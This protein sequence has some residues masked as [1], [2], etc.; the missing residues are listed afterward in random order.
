MFN[1]HQCLQIISNGIALELTKRTTWLALGRFATDSGFYGLSQKPRLQ[2][3]LNLF[4]PIGEYGS[5]TSL[6]P[7]LPYTEK[8]LLMT[9]YC[10]ICKTFLEAIEHMLL[11]CSWTEPL[12]FSLQVCRNPSDIGLSNIAQWIYDTLARDAPDIDSWTFYALW[13]IWKTRNDVVFN[14]KM[15][16]PMNVFYQ[17]RTHC[18]EF[19]SSLRTQHG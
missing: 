2:Y 10:P 13:L 9:P 3:R 8:D 4:D 16:D 19:I 12:W 14:G 15:P 1:P 17:I 18:H 11:L 6:C 7:L 5:K